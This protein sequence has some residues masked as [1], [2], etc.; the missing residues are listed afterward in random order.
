MTNRKK[1]IEVALPLN[2]RIGER[3]FCGYRVVHKITPVTSVAGREA[4]SR[5]G[6][7]FF[8]AFPWGSAFLQR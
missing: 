7:S 4:A 2:E 6:L 8:Q 3:R 1:L 5:G